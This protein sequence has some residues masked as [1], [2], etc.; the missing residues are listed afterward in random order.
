[1]GGSISG[2]L[3][4]VNPSEA[5]APWEPDKSNPFDLKW[6]GHLFRRATFGVGMDRL[7][8]AVDTGFEPTM[9]EL[10]NGEVGAVNDYHTRERIAL[11][12]YEDQ[13]KMTPESQQDPF[14]LQAWWFDLLFNSMHPLRESAFDASSA[15]G[16]PIDCPCALRASRAAARR[17]RPSSSS[18]SATLAGTP[19]PCGAPR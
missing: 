19:P 17:S 13:Q 14:E 3:D 2:P 6:A 7:R 18:S 8:A 10:L 15:L 11:K 5:W 9:T 1:M 4:K 12:M 16:R